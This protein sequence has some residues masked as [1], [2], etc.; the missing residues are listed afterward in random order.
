MSMI[1]RI[2]FYRRA[3]RFEGTSS[4]YPES[5]LEN[6]ETCQSEGGQGENTLS[7]IKPENSLFS[8]ATPFKFYI[9]SL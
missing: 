5:H 9:V 2:I 6:H 4:R 8:G 3:N 1:P 7:S